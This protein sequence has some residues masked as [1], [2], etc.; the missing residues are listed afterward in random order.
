MKVY[1]YSEA[2]RL[3]ARILDEAREG[4]EVRVRRQDGTEF[5]IR[6]VERRGS[7]LDVPGVEA[8]VTR[9]EI[10]EAIRESRRGDGR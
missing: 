8:G 1:T 5:S 2:R 7:P 4:G 6:P 9:E 3:F 10:L